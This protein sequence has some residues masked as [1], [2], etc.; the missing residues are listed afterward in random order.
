MFLHDDVG[1]NLKM[2]FFLPRQF[3]VSKKGTSLGDFFKKLLYKN[4]KFTFLKCAFSEIS[5]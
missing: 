4:Q 1:K 5:E 2:I 3:M